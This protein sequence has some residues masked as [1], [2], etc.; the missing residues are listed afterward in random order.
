M[1][2][3]LHLWNLEAQATISLRLGLHWAAGL[4]PILD[5]VVPSAMHVFGEQRWLVHCLAL[6]I[7]D[8]PSSKERKPAFLMAEDSLCS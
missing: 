2:R 6:S 3:H 8:A 4:T 7:V 5:M 1:G